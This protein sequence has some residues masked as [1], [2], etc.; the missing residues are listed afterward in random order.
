[1][2]RQWNAMW[3]EYKKK[4]HCDS[5]L[6]LDEVRYDAPRGVEASFDLLEMIEGKVILHLTRRIHIYRPDFV[7]FLLYH[8]FTH[9]KDYIEYPFEKPTLADID[10]RTIQEDNVNTSSDIGIFGTF[11]QIHLPQKMSGENQLEGDAGKKLFNYMNTYSEFHACRIALGEVLGSPQPGKPIDVMKNQ[12]PGPFRDISIQR[13]LSDCLRHAHIAYK[14]FLALLVPQLFVLYF[15]QIMYLFGYMSHFDHDISTLKQTFAVLGVTGLEKEYLDVYQALKD[16]DIQAILDSCD[17][18]YRDSYIPF[19]KEY[20]RR[21]YDPG[22]YTEDE[23]DKI[24][25]E[26]Y[27]AFVEMIAN[28]KGGRLWSGRV[29]PIFG[30]H[31][32]GRAYGAADPETI[33]EMVRKSQELPNGH[34]KTDF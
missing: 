25:P 13:M 20:I 4:Y 7:R 6:L 31:D 9:L 11:G 17:L 2:L 3:C 26:N 12:I 34:M 18:L 22:L 8:E 19:V 1:M 16:Q 29:S 30:V 10:R 15:R 28:R 32:V 27:H 24:T 5:P 21:N 23:L 33:R 14:K